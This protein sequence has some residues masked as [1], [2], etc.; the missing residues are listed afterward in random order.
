MPRSSIKRRSTRAEPESTGRPNRA[1]YAAWYTA[2][3][4]RELESLGHVAKARVAAK[5]NAFLKEWREGTVDSELSNTWDY[6][7]LKGADAKK[8]KVK[9]IH[10]LDTYRVVF[11]VLDDSTCVCF[12]D[13]FLKTFT[14]DRREVQRAVDRA[15][16]VQERG[17]CT[18]EVEKKGDCK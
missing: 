6:K 4:D 17:Y 10:V 18:K 12:V 7:T 5:I 13:V 2:W 3:F 8:A 9:Q 15:R 14:S 11:V 1:D 16:E